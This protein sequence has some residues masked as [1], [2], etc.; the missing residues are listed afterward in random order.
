MERLRA[1]EALADRAAAL[2]ARLEAPPPTSWRPDDA[3][4]GHPRVLVGELVT[5]DVG[6]TAW[7]EK[8][9]AVL[10]DVEGQLW[11]VWLL[12]RVLIDEFVRQQPK[13]GEVLALAY[14]GRV[15][16]GAGAS[17]Y[18]KYRLVVDRD[19]SAVRWGAGAAVPTSAGEDSSSPAAPAA[20]ACVSC[21]L[22]DGHEAGCELDPEGVPF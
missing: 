17:G 10:R 7:G 22:V 21:G 13:I 6:H 16:G 5:V 12:H 15:Q 8:Q 4:G 20:A 19:P 11:S 18:E 1:G 14:D 2:A 9:I 3:P